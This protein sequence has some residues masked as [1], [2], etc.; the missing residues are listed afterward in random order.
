MTDIIRDI[1]DYD[2]LA[3]AEK[4]TGKSIHDDPLTQTIGFSDFIEHNKMKDSVLSSMDDTVFN[5]SLEGY[6]RKIKEE[7]FVEIL[8]EPFQGHYSEIFYV[9]YHIQDGILLKFDTYGGNRVNGGNFC[10][11]WIPQ[12]GENGIP[13]EEA[14]RCTSSGGYNSDWLWAG[15]HDC[16]EALRYHIASLRKHGRFV[17]PWVREPFLWLLHY[18]DVKEENYDH[19]E[20][21]QRRLD[22]IIP[23]ILDLSGH[24]L[25]KEEECSS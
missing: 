24:S 5:D 25:V 14:F 13:T 19:K 7:G 22:Q 16:R 23:K 2:A 20:I 21:T 1:L 10:Y 17:T 18:M 9:F 12:L 8:A 15:D 4:Q 11:N 3:N 6:L